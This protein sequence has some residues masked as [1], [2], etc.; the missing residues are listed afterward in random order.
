MREHI[1]DAAEE[2]FAQQGFAATP[3][4]EI[5]EKVNVNPAMIHYYF[6]SKRA[7]LRDARLRRFGLTSAALVASW[8]LGGLSAWA[9]DHYGL[10]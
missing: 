2:L 9:A 4:R 10:Y 7:L 8:G 1:L 5:A 3:V 6:G